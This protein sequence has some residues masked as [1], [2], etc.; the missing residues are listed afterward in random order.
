M[1]SQSV[2]TDLRRKVFTE[3]A[4]VAYESENPSNDLEEIPFKITPDEIPKYR[5]WD[6]LSVPR[7]NPYIS[8]R[9]LRRAISRKSIT[10]R[11]L[12]R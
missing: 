8:P 10:N 7:I 12:C 1:K 3:V 4:R 2:V 11:L 6:F 5:E 9:A